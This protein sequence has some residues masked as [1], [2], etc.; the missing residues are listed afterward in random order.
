[1]AGILAAALREVSCADHD[2][3]IALHWRER[4]VRQVVGIQAVRRTQTKWAMVPW[5]YI[6]IAIRFLS[7][8]TASPSTLTRPHFSA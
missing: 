6:V 5:R 3:R 2:L 8:V 1:M 4:R 7:L